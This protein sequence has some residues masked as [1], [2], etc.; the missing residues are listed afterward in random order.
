MEN[1]LVVERLLPTWCEVDSNTWSKHRKMREASL[2]WVQVAAAWDLVGTWLKQKLASTQICN[3]MISKA[4]YG[5]SCHISTLLH[6]Q[7]DQ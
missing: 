2:C 6:L 7:W 5:V 1:L 4:C 3:V